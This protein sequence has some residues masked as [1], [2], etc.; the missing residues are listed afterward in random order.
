M[1]L[2]KPNVLLPFAALILILMLPLILGAQTGSVLSVRPSADALE[3]NDPLPFTVAIAVADG[4]MYGSGSFTLT[5]DASILQ[6]DSFE[7]NDNLIGVV[8][9]S[10]AGIIRFNALSVT[11]ASGTLLL[12][13]GQFTAL[14]EGQ[15]NLTLGIV[16]A[17]ADTTGNALPDVS[18][19][20]EVITVADASETPT[21]SPT[22]T[23]TPEMTETPSATETAQSTKTVMPTSTVTPVTTNMPEITQ[24]PETTQTPE[25][26]QMPQATETAVPTE[27]SLPV[28]TALPTSTPTTEATSVATPASVPEKFIYLPLISIE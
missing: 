3:I 25:V 17:P 5:Y 12:G 22:I 16:D 18:I 11:G 9:A 24:T 28:S 21:T 7:I 14:A 6:L 13:S 27:P 19:M 20:D 1:K 2:L 10:E 23:N 15:T 26:T 8:N 4:S